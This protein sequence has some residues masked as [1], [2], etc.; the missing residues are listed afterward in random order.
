MHLLLDV[1]QKHGQFDRGSILS[2]FDRK[3]G[4]AIL[5]PRLSRFDRAALS[6]FYRQREN[7]R[8]A[9]AQRQNIASAIKKG[10]EKAEQEGGE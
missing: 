10:E 9:A 8:T 5:P 1:K 7:N 4:A 3:G 2:L 6:G